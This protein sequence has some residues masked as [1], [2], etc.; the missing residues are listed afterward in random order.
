MCGKVTF[1]Q[2]IPLTWLPNSRV[3][4]FHQRC[5][6]PNVQHPR[7]HLNKPPPCSKL[8]GWVKWW[9]GSGS[10][11][12]M[13]PPGTL[14]WILFTEKMTFR[15]LPLQRRRGD[16]SPWPRTSLRERK[17]SDPSEGKVQS[18]RRQTTWETTLLQPNTMENRMSN[19]SNVY[20]FPAS[21]LDLWILCQSWF[22]QNVMFHC[23]NWLKILFNGWCGWY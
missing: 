15:K 19:D 6:T 7:Q 14:P 8:W 20:L 10:W 17:D 2:V 23:F 13:Q 11:K 18:L 1:S 12:T 4:K 9:V 22:N 3:A 5:Q 21:G 16:G